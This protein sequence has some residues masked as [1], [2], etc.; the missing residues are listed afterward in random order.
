LG[1]LLQT[2]IDVA[3]LA[4]SAAIA[5]FPW[6]EPEEEPEEVKQRTIGRVRR[7]LRTHIL[8]RAAAP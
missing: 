1:R 7:F 3:S 4:P 5:V 6:Q 2:S 8:I